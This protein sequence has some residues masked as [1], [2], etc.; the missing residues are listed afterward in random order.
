M[1]KT[2]KL[3]KKGKSLEKRKVKFSLQQKGI[4]MK[5]KRAST[6]PNRV[7]PGAD[8]PGTQLRTKQKIKRLNMYNEKPD[9]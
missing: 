2:L 3:S 7:I 8:A 9:L 1:P 4:K 5:S 6:N